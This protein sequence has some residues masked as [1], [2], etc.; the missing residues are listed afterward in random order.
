MESQK[1]P[2]V[3]ETISRRSVMKIQRLTLALSVFAL[4][5]ASA[6]SGY[7]V[8]ITAPL[9]AGA[10]ELKPGEYQVQVENGKAV[11]KSNKDKKNTVEV[12][13]KMETANAKFQTTALNSAKSGG[14]EKLEAIEI[15][16][17]NTRIVMESSGAQNAGE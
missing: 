7:H 5:V 10:T 17:T 6:A 13:A 12:P 15:G 1:T 16:G 11:F 14:K 2:K 8:T 3:F 4:G 9:W